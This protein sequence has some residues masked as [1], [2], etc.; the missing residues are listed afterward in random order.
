MLIP[1]TKAASSAV[2]TRLCF[3]PLKIIGFHF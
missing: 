3:R 1:R 2:S